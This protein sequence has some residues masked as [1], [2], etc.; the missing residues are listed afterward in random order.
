M[1]E[2]IQTVTSLSS[3]SSFVVKR[4][5]GIAQYG[6]V[7]L[8]EMISS[9]SSS[10]S[11]EDNENAETEMPHHVAVKRVFL[12][13]LHAR[14]AQGL[15]LEDPTQEIHFAEK[16][17]MESIAAGR[18]GHEN[19]VRLETAFVVA[20]GNNSSNCLLIVMEFCNQGD[21][22]Q[23]L[24]ATEANRFPEQD[25][26]AI[27]SHIL[28]GL[29][30]LHRLGIAHR[31]LSLE[32]VLVKDG[33]CKISDFGLAIDTNLHPKSQEIVGKRFYMAPEVVQGD[34]YD[35]KAADIWSLGILLFILLTGSPL[36]TF[37]A[38][39]QLGVEKVLEQW[40]F[41]SSL[42]PETMDLLTKMLQMDPTKRWQVEE[43]VQHPALYEWMRKESP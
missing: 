42:E 40:G 1:Q 24:E 29:R 17:L 38:F 35:P 19:I 28:S 22:F 43:L 30:F 9:S 41:A 31:D 20:S 10:A 8:C 5:L 2:S 6:D 26:L 39:S 32:N 25:A 7:L 15:T 21:L 16:M 14:R 37:H 3:S 33:I 11:A 34:W 23:H 27:F 18:G 36:V 4:K 12:D 13:Q